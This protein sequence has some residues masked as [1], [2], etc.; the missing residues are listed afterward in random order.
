[1][2]KRRLFITGGRSLVGGACSLVAI[3]CQL[4]APSPPDDHCGSGG[5]DTCGE[6]GC[7]AAQSHLSSMGCALASDPNFLAACR[8]IE[9][10]QAAGETELDVDTDCLAAAESCDAAEG[11]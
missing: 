10:Q 9:A 3:G 11:C 1:M 6:A 8:N 2:V 5:S 7:V 4:P